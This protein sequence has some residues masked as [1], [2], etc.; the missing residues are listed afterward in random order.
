MG[1]KPS[2]QRGGLQ[3]RSPPSVKHVLATSDGDVTIWFEKGRKIRIIAP[4]K[5]KIT[6]IPVDKT[7][8]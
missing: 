4:P 8:G 5:I 3:R 1:T 7:T 2:N 6:T